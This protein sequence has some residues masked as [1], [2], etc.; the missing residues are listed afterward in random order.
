M[1]IEILLGICVVLLITIW[2]IC[3]F[4][5]KDESNGNESGNLSAIYGAPSSD[6]E[7]ISADT[8][9]EVIEQAR[10]ICNDNDKCIGFDTYQNKDGSGYSATIIYDSK[11]YCEQDENVKLYGRDPNTLSDIC[12]NYRYFDNDVVEER[13]NLVYKYLQN[14]KLK[15]STLDSAICPYS[16]T[17][18]GSGS[19]PPSGLNP[20]NSDSGSETMLSLLNNFKS[21][22]TVK[23][24]PLGMWPSSS[25]YGKKPQENSNLTSNIPVMLWDYL[26]TGTQEDS[27]NAIIGNYIMGSEPAMYE[28]SVNTN[29]KNGGIN[30]QPDWPCTDSSIVLGGGYS[31]SE[32]ANK[33]INKCNIGSQSPTLSNMD[34]WGYSENTGIL[35]NGFLGASL[36]KKTS[37]TSCEAMATTNYL[38]AVRSVFKTFQNQMTENGNTFYLA[39]S[40]KKNGDTTDNNGNPVWNSYYIK[41]IDPSKLS[42]SQMMQP[43]TAKTFKLNNSLIEEDEE[44]DTYDLSDMF[45]Y[46]TGCTESDNLNY[47][48]DCQF[49]DPEAC[50]EKII[51]GCTD[52]S[53]CNYDENAN[54]DDGSCTYPAENEDCEGNCL[55][56]YIKVNNVCVPIVE[57]CMESAN[58][59]NSRG[60]SPCNI[61]ATANV[62][63]EKYVY[64]SS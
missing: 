58:N 42:D 61:D 21:Q 25:C 31:S 11:S 36:S 35:E 18:N 54:V 33:G 28:D 46:K 64:I 16:D 47:C 1:F 34:G 51:N 38:D 8:E 37:N 32:E 45:E 24:V 41:Y 44:Y 40:I 50:G 2:I 23:Q 5:P 55:D 19:V 60:Q 57:G 15:D 39:F 14:T 12:K 43:L 13:K 22:A 30:N 53:A 52:N 49:P 29:Y 9:E 10:D 27:Y 17:Y 48:D 62:N 20:C 7:T 6:N 63:N 4:S 3:L 59:T 56:G 26:K